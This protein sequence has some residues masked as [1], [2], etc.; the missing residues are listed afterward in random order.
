MDWGPSCPPVHGI[1]QARILEWVAISFSRGS[2]QPRSPALQADSLPSEPPSKYSRLVLS[3]LFLILEETLFSSNIHIHPTKVDSHYLIGWIIGSEK[4]VMWRT[5]L[6][7]S[8][9]GCFQK[10]RS[11]ADQDVHLLSACP[12]SIIL[13]TLKTAAGGDTQA[14]RVCVTWKSPTT[15]K[16]SSQD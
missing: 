11:W 6:W 1:L 12:V 13:T 10:Q 16:K 2:S 7:I 15:S 4:V 9:E 3:L 8:R 5:A 14:Q